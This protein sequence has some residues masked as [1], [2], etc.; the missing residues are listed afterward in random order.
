MD[1]VTIGKRLLEVSQST[2]GSQGASNL[3]DSFGHALAGAVNTLDTPPATNTRPSS[4]NV[5]VC[6]CLGSARF[7]V[8]FQRPVPGS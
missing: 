3:A 4:N 5:P 8:T 7:P 1:P 2:P 6:A